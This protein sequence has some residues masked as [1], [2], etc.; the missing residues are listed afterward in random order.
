MQ[1]RFRGISD[2]LE[3]L[4]GKVY[5]VLSIE[6]GWYRIVDETGEDYLFPPECFEITE[7]QDDSV[8]VL[9][10][11]QAAARARSQGEWEQQHKSQDVLAFDWGAE[12]LETPI[13][14]I[15]VTVDGK[16]ATVEVM[17]RFSR[18]AC[19]G[20]TTYFV[21][22]GVDSKK[23][24]QVIECRLEPTGHGAMYGSEGERFRSM[25]FESEGYTLCISA[26]ENSPA[27]GYDIVD[28]TL[29]VIPKGLRATL[30]P[31]APGQW[32]VFG[33][34]WIGGVAEQQRD[35]A[36]IDSNPELLGEC[37]VDMANEACGRC[38]KCGQALESREK[39]GV[40]EA[41]CPSCGVVYVTDAS[42]PMDD[43]LEEYTVTLKGPTPI[44]KA[45][46]SAVNK[47][48]GCGFSKAKEILSSGPAAI[49]QAEARE[50]AQVIELLDNAGLEYSV[51]PEFPYRNSGR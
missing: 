35:A 33:V 37:W 1:V 13:G 23:K 6:G 28:Y 41:M 3:L 24:P 15:V 45:A 26:T 30:R 20:V 48:L 2:P 16:P 42:D 22:V 14:P 34:S 31:K 9:T 17:R 39:D 32:V 12:S 8:K 40:L 29:E 49:S 25:E 7:P 18:F 44:T 4:N 5:D 11:K 19:I 10:F 51:S 43:D 36:S 38:P 46:L 27:D 50:T 47:I 21:G